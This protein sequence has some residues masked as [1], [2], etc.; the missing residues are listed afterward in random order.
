MTGGKPPA[1]VRRSYDFFV[2]GLRVHAK[3]NNVAAT[4]IMTAPNIH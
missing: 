3:K 2:T 1:F 4:R